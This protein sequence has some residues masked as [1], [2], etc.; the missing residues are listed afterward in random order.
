MTH[1]SDRTMAFSLLENFRCNYSDI[2][3]HRIV[4]P[5]TTNP[6]AYIRLPSREVTLTSSAGSS[7]S[8]TDRT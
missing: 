2:V 3:L 6:P 1:A 7:S 8:S 4:D 5:S